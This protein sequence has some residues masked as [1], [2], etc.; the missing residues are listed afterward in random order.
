MYYGASEHIDVGI[1]LG[2]LVVVETWTNVH[3]HGCGLRVMG[4]H[5]LPHRIFVV[6]AVAAAEGIEQTVDEQ[7]GLIYL[8]TKPPPRAKTF[9]L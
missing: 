3:T 1:S 6:N 4:W 2:Q 9:G 7:F 8:E 5:G